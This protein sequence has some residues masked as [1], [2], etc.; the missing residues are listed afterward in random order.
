MQDSQPAGGLSQ[1]APGGLEVRDIRLDELSKLLALYAHLHAD[2]DALP[3]SREVERIWSALHA[4]PSHVY[5]GGFLGAELVSACNAA[6]IANLTRGARPYALIE[7]V[8][9]HP[10]V[11]GRG[12]GKAVLNALIERCWQCN[13]YK[14]MLMSGAQ[15]KNAHAFYEALGFD[16]QQKQAFVMTR[17]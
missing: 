16:R 10:S 6:I 17:R 11:R 9:T 3:D 15:R 13:C 1:R 8:V 2:D 5:L 7:N 14:V 12:V 4:D